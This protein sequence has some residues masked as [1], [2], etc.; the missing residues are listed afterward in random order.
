[1]SMTKTTARPIHGDAVYAATP[2]TARV[3]KTSSGA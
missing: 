1:M 3:R 2:A